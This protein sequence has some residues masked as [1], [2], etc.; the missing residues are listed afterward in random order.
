MVRFKNAIFFGIFPEAE[1]SIKTTT[2]RGVFN[3]TP[4]TGFADTARS[5]RIANLPSLPP[6]A[7]VPK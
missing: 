1:T 4:L 6:F 2:D 3:K 7:A 5:D